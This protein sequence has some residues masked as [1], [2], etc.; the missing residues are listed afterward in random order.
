MQRKNR[1]PTSRGFD[2]E[3]LHVIKEMAVDIIYLPERPTER[4]WQPEQA[5]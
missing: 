4:M 1:G 3:P 5:I 2:S